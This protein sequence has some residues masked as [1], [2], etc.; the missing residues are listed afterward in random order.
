M[1]DVPPEV[2]EVFD[3]HNATFFEGRLSRPVILIAPSF[4]RTNAGY[5]F[6][7]HGIFLLIHPATL[8]KSRTFWSD[9]LLH[10][11]VHHS[12]A[13]L[14]G[15]HDQAYGEVFAKEASRVHA[16][17]GLPGVVLPGQES[18]VWPQQWRRAAY[19]PGDLK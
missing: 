14:Q 1:S 13:T 4:A 9:T 18:Y 11:M 6:T 17:L 3:A 8:K 15:V 7:E 12:V 10:G 19:A 2:W 5:S 16:L